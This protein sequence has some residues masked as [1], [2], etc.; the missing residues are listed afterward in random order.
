MEDAQARARAAARARARS[1]RPPSRRRPPCPAACARGRGRRRRRCPRRAAPRRAAGRAVA[2]RHLRPWPRSTRAMPDIPAPP[3]PIRWS[4]PLT[5][6]PARGAGARPR[7]PRRRRAARRCASPPRIAASRAG[8][9]RS[10]ADRRAGARRRAPRPRRSP[11]RRPRRNGRVRELMVGCG[12][13]IGYEQRGQHRPPRAPR[14][15]PPARLTPRS[16][17]ASTVQ[18][19]SVFASDAVALGRRRHRAGHVLVSRVPVTCRTM[20]S[21]TPSPR[22]RPRRRR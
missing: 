14:R 22:T 21:S 3:I 18:K 13:G 20:P 17:A 5:P 8:S 7:R 12:M 16:A 2:A 6:D 11:H 19:R 15:V 4:S 9:A 1:P 10:S